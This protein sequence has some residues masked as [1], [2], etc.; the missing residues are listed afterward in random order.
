[1]QDETNLHGKEIVQKHIE[2]LNALTEIEERHMDYF[3]AR[4]GLFIDDDH[5]YLHNHYS[6]RIN[7]GVVSFGFIDGSGIAKE[8]ENE[9]L[10]AFK[11]HH[12][13]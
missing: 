2:F 1:M 7:E 11:K 5:D 6:T 9:C 10:E 12:Q 13:S 4:P 8:I 3:K